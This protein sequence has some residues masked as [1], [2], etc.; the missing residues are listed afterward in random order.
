[1]ADENTEFDDLAADPFEAE[2]VAYLDGELDAEAAR[3]VEARLA[4]DPAAR[5]RAA[6]LKKTFDMLDYLPKAE[7][8]P[9]FATRTL[10]KLPAIKPAASRSGS[11]PA[12]VSTSMP[13]A[14]LEDEPPQAVRSRSLLRAAGVFA[15]VA[16]FAALG[17]F[18]TA[19]ARPLL[20]PVSEKE[21]EEARIEP[22]VEA[23]A[24][25]IEH[26]PLYAVADDI[27][28][29]TELG[30]PELFGE[31]PAV[32]YDVGLKIP[33]GDTTDT[34]TGKQFETLAK[35]FR[36]LPVARR[37]E[38][39]KLDHDLHAKEPKERDRLFRVL[40]AYAVW[41]DRLPDA[42][43]RG[44]LRAATPALRL[45]V[46]ASIREQQWMEVLPPP[47][48]KKAASLTNPAEKAE[49]IQHWK[50]EE[51]IRRDRWAFIRQH[52]EAFAANKSPWPFDT[53][54][55]RKEVIEF[56]RTTFRTD[57]PKRC[58]LTAEELGEYRRTL[59]VAERDGAWAW[60][61]LTVYELSK[62]HPYLPEPAE[63]KHM[64]MDLGDLPDPISKLL[65]KGGPPRLRAVSGRWPEFPLEL[66]R[67]LQGG[68]NPFFPPLGPCRLNDFKS[69]VRDFATKELFPKLTSDE[70]AA[71]QRLEGRWPDYPREFVRLATKYDI[72]V[73]G[74]TLPGPPRKWDSTY[75]VRL[76]PRPAN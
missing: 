28:F 40:E 13:V 53:E 54:S 74:V 68:K 2:L 14:L 64:L 23:D 30:K 55:G 75:D 11:R 48:R 15:A 5:A 27:A 20:F 39:T 70:R 57:D 45:R 17:Y 49:L 43:R 19:A 46:V 47:L 36:A 69:P 29:V 26:L 22:K 8:S 76:R 51:A 34:P 12:A 52:A 72:A 16:V 42:E 41:L 73:P 66:H 56:A 4:T 38:V 6:A 59:T 25:V 31:E 24:R 35:A 65:R 32:A 62:L 67:E 58:R 9:S 71:L 37:A 60:Y 61:G 3:K 1:M 21:S 33:G 18:A 7:P 10:D 50:D 44:V 63:S